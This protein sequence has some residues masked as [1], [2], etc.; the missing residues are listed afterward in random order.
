MHNCIC[1]DVRR[2]AN[3]RICGIISVYAILKTQLYVGKYAKFGFCNICDRM[4][5]RMFSYNRYPY[6]CASV[7]RALLAPEILSE[8]FL[9]CRYFT[10]L[11]WRPW[12]TSCKFIY[13][14]RKAIYNS[15]FIWFYLAAGACMFTS[16]VSSNLHLFFG[17]S[18]INF[19]FLFV[20]LCVYFSANIHWWSFI[21][22]W[23][24]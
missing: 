18:A 5:D 9:K 22:V 2:Y 16:S 10:A 12:L 14:A 20:C 21:R 3:F 1:G 23:S 7:Q 4:C 6:N 13:I 19:I 11:Y 24:L 8:S 17:A 15:L